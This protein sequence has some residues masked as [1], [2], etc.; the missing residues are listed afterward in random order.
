MDKGYLQTTFVPLEKGERENDLD[1]RA[2]ADDGN[3]S[4]GVALLG[5]DHYYR[6]KVYYW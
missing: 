1:I 3:K 6:R 2:S 4:T 5:L